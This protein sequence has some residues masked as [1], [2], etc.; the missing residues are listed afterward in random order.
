MKIHLLPD[1]PARLNLSHG[2]ANYNFQVSQP[3]ILEIVLDIVLYM[4]L[5]VGSY[6]F[7][8]EV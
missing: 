3:G 1:S 2:Y 8:L 4:F 5:R 7:K 6:R